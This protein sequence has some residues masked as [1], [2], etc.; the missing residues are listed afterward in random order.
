MARGDD[1]KL[2]Q[3]EPRNLKPRRVAGVAI[4]ACA[5]VC[6]VSSLC[7]VVFVNNQERPRQVT[8]EAAPRTNHVFAG[9]A[10]C[11]T[12]GRAGRERVTHR[13]DRL[14]Y[15]PHDE[16]RQAPL[17]HEH[18]FTAPGCGAVGVS[19]EHLLRVRRK[20]QTDQRICDMTYAII[21]ACEG[22]ALELEGSGSAEIR[23]YALPGAALPQ[24]LDLETYMLHVD[25]EV[26]LRGL[27]WEPSDTLTKQSSVVGI[28]PTLRV[29][30]SGCIAWVSTAI[31][32]TSARTTW[33]SSTGANAWQASEFT[34]GR[35]ACSD[36]RQTELSVTHPSSN[37]SIVSRAYQ[38]GR[39]T[40]D[41]GRDQAAI[42]GGS[43]RLGSGGE[44]LPTARPIAD[45]IDEP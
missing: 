26:Y 39:L 27:G 44:A 28:A 18:V 1:P 11:E 42:P 14:G 19:A 17:N 36:G 9:L 16:W 10:L 45:I 4:A 43:M 38:I 8:P 20:G 12:E 34:V 25:A 22:D 5:L 32:F 41:F 40:P 35:V 33:E 2:A 24:D 13:L 31:G 15:V 37:G 29:P 30:S 23:E 21:H 3:S 6:V 7:L